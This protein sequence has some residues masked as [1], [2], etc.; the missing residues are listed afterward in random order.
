M[1]AYRSQSAD[2]TE[3]EYAYVYGGVRIGMAAPYITSDV[4][5][6]KYGEAKGRP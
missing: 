5:P 2:K 3:S 4:G 6:Y 1:I